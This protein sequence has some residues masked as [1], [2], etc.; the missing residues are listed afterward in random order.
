MGEEKGYSSIAPRGGN[1]QIID[2]EQLAISNWQ[3]AKCRYLVL[4]I[5]YLVEGFDPLP[6]GI[7]TGFGIGSPKGH[8][9]VSQGSPKRG[10]RAILGS[11][12]SKC[13]I[14]NKISKIG[15]GGGRG[16][17]QSPRTPTSHVIGKPALTAHERGAALI[18]SS[19]PELTPGMNRVSTLES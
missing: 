13:F 11:K 3:L 12:L 6:A 9:S 5:S 17:R 15:V 19:N 16:T 18:K 2:K 1:A 7:G 10:A 4:G 14:C 8:P